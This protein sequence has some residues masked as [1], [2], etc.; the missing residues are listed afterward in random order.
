[1]T[2][3]RKAHDARS[4]DHSIKP[5]TLAE[6][7][8]QVMDARSRT[9]ALVRWAAVLE[10]RQLA[11]QLLRVYE[12]NPDDDEIELVVRDLFAHVLPARIPTGGSESEYVLRLEATLEQRRAFELLLSKHI[13]T[14][15]Q[16]LDAFRRETARLIESGALR[17]SA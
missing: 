3:L 7:A 6:D 4:G 15:T 12:P 16:R 11:R 5:A 8:M 2:H 17:E 14:R 10:C 13:Q 9:P 1:M